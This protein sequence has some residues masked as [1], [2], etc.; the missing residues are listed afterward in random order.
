M[1]KAASSYWRIVVSLHHQKFST[2]WK[3]KINS[4][5]PNSYSYMEICI[6]HNC[7]Q[8]TCTYN[9]I[10]ERKRHVKLGKIIKANSLRSSYRKKIKLEIRMESCEIQR[11]TWTLRFIELIIRKKV[12]FC[13]ISYLSVVTCYY[14]ITLA[15]CWNPVPVWIIY[16]LYN[17]RTLLLYLPHFRRQSVPDSYITIKSPWKV[18]YVW[19]SFYSRQ[20][21][22]PVSSLQHNWLK[23]YDWVAY[24]HVDILMWSNITLWMYIVHD[25]GSYTVTAVHEI[26]S[27]LWRPIH[28][29]P[30]KHCN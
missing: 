25:T 23:K 16:N 12:V 4:N 5:A 6:F 7:Y 21:F 17:C 29:L 10:T 22:P 1:L 14:S 15:R 24:K 19:L 30:V 3:F 20:H 13:S 26:W 11:F 2:F 28:S 8:Y 27:H 18:A 9:I